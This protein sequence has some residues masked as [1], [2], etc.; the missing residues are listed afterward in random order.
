MLLFLLERFLV[1]AGVEAAG[2]GVDTPQHAATLTKGSPGVLHGSLSYL[3]QTDDGQIVDPHS[4]SAGLDYPGAAVMP[5]AA[6]AVTHVSCLPARSMR[7][8]ATQQ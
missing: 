6:Q 1:H 8:S 7:A 3:I 4:I 5:G 2:Y